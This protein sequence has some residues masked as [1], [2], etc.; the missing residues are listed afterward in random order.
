M[1]SGAKPGRNLHPLLGKIHRIL[2]EVS[3]PVQ[4]AGIAP[5]YW[6]GRIC[7]VERDM[8]GHIESAVGR[9][10]FL[11]QSRKLDLVE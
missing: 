9:D 8:D 11:E 2:D 1:T 7:T 5:V 4:N 10:D 3:Q 6:L